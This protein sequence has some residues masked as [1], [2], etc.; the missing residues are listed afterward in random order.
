MSLPSLGGP[1]NRDVE[2][3][4]VHFHIRWG[5]GT[6]SGKLD[7]ERH[8]TRSDAER[9]AK[10]LAGPYETYNIEKADE[11]C[12]VCKMGRYGAMHAAASR[13]E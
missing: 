4:A 6:F 7:W 1:M 11:K 2:S 10:R 3:P 9:S 13:G 5:S 12:I 8:A